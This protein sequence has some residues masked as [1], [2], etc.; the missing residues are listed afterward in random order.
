MGCSGPVIGSST[1]YILIKFSPLTTGIMFLTSQILRTATKWR[2]TP[3]I[4]NRNMQNSIPSL[5]C[6]FR[7]VMPLK[8]NQCD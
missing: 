2:S 6:S 1:T 5:I 3:Q 7:Y 4:I 8:H